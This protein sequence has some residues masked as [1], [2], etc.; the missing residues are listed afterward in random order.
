MT[1]NQ[2]E[3]AILNSELEES[4]YQDKKSFMWKVMMTE[5]LQDEFNTD[6]DV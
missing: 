3:D 2:I 1:T 4:E 5:L 6:E